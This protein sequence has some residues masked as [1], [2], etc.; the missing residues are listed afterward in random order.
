MYLTDKDRHM[1]KRKERHLHQA[2]RLSFAMR[3]SLDA[4]FPQ[5]VKYIA[6]KAFFGHALL[7][8]QLCDQIDE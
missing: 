2:D 4:N 5:I 8:I 1:K 3:L 6:Q 7:Q